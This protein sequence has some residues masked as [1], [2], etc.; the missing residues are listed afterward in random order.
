MAFFK[1]APSPKPGRLDKNDLIICVGWH[2]FVNWP[3]SGRLREPVPLVGAG[4]EAIANDLLDG[5]EVEIMAW[6]PHGKGGLSYQVRRLGEQAV[7]WIRAIY[8]RRDREPAASA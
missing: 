5:Q 3:Q 2:A 4:G 1:K 6:R 7:W 8:L